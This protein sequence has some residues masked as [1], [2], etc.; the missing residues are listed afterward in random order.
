M[1]YRQV[2]E[3]FAVTGQ[4][5]AADVPAVKAAG[6]KTMICNRPDAE[7]GAM[8]HEAIEAAAKAAG[9]EFRYIPVVSGA[10][11]PE[12]V[13][14][15]ADALDEVAGPVFAYCRSGARSTNLYMMA[16]QLRG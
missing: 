13:E 12:D 16:K 15:M 7:D 11:T 10:I 3:D 14:K 5:T 6:F 9:L 1:E 2:T 4:I 8:P